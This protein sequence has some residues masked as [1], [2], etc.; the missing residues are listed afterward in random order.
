MQ[1]LPLLQRIMGGSLTAG[2]IAHDFYYT[3]KYLDFGIAAVV[4]L[5]ALLCFHVM[6]YFNHAGIAEIASLNDQKKIERFRLVVT[7]ITTLFCVAD[8]INNIH[9]R[10]Q[11][12]FS[13]KS[14][15]ATI[16]SLLIVIFPEAVFNIIFIF[17]I[18]KK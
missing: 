5:T 12:Y 9:L 16:L 7:T 10:N 15:S 4:F 18:K 6:V 11:G 2:F 14:I 3:N 13:F 17:R 1:L 8:C